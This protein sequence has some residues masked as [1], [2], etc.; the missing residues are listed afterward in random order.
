MQ[1]KN[2]TNVEFLKDIQNIHN[3]RN[4]KAHF[5]MKHLNV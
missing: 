2:N 4:L 3:K 5:E 1:H